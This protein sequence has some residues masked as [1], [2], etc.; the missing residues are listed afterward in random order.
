MQDYILTTKPA[1]C[2]CHQLDEIHDLLAVRAPIE[3][4]VCVGL[5]RV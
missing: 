5:F 4:K 3:V 1:S 2:L